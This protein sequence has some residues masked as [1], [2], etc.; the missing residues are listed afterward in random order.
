[1]PVENEFFNS[2]SFEDEMFNNIYQKNA[3]ENFV[4]F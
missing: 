1:M 4:N 3:S 2:M